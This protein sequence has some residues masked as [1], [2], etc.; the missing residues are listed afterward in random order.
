M[1]GPEGSARCIGCDKVFYVARST[2]MEGFPGD[3]ADFELKF[4]M[5]RKPVELLQD[6]P[7]AG[8]LG[9]SCDDSCSCILPF[10]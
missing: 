8:V 7:Y 4:D 10:L 9:A 3:A 1:V 2:V 6:G 5:D